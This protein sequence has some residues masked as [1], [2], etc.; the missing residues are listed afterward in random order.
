[1]LRG[2]EKGRGVPY[3]SISPRRRTCGLLMVIFEVR[4]CDGVVQLRFSLMGEVIVYVAVR[5]MVG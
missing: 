4:V 1:M 2:M 5:S 3:W